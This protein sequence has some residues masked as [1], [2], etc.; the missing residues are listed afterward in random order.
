MRIC[1]YGIWTYACVCTIAF[2][3]SLDKYLSDKLRQSQLKPLEIGEV[4]LTLAKLIPFDK[5][6][7]TEWFGGTSGNVFDFIDELI[8][9]QVLLKS[10]ADNVEN[11]LCV[12]NNLAQALSVLCQNAQGLRKT[13]TKAEEQEAFVQKHLLNLAEHSLKITDDKIVMNFAKSAADNVGLQQGLIL[14]RYGQILHALV[15][16][17]TQ[18]KEYVEWE[19]DFSKWI[20]EIPKVW[21]PHFEIYIYKY[22]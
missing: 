19:K 15:N 2:E 22:I 21:S 14:H 10:N 5:L 4:S 18:Q 17:R 20:I 6:S 7:A 12:V 3:Q 8:D 9:Q 13:Q 16:V 11:A 1:S